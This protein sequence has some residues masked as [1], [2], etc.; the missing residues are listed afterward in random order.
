MISQGPVSRH[1]C[2]LHAGHPHD[3]H[4]LLRLRVNETADGAENK[5]ENI[6]LTFL[7]SPATNRASMSWPTTMKDPTLWCFVESWSSQ[8]FSPLVPLLNHSWGIHRLACCSCCLV[9]DALFL[10]A[11]VRFQLH[12]YIIHIKASLGLNAS[13]SSIWVLSLVFKYVRP[14]ILH[15]FIPSNKHYC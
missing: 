8:I 9:C 14:Y 3:S 10:Q 13:F 2:E 6:G 1:E 4:L 7:L 12:I 5:F 15:L 11:G